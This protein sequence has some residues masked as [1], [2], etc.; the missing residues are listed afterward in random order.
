[1]NGTCVQDTL[2][3]EQIPKEDIKKDLVANTT[4]KCQVKCDLNAHCTAFYF[5]EKTCSLIAS[6]KLLKGNGHKDPK[7]FKAHFYCFIK[8]N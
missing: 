4:Q 8:A 2:T 1:M 5:T 6:E 7:D 3:S